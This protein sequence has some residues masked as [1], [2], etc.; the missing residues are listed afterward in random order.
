MDSVPPQDCIQ[1]ANNGVTEIFLPQ[2]TT[3]Q[4]TPLTVYCDQTSAGGGWLMF[5][6]RMNNAEDFPNR[7]WQEYKEGFG[8]LTGSF[9]LGLEYLHEIT[10][11]PATLRITLEDWDG[12]K[13]YAQY[14]DFS[15][16]GED[17]GYR[18]S[19]GS[20]SGDAGDSL[21]YHNGKKFSTIDKDQ[22]SD[23]WHLSQEYGGAWW[24]KD[25]LMYSQLT[26]HYYSSGLN[27]GEHG[28]GV[29]WLRW[30][31]GYYSFKRADDDAEALITA[32]RARIEMDSS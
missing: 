22:D 21:N 10:K 19:V 3:N 9:W 20:Y 6:R 26:G 24:Y 32:S 13:K 11:R 2:P 27:S 28:F 17:D 14:A 12:T 1:S 25:D 15:I 7:V 5:L 29:W 23:S 16:S 8:D 31:G 30:H 4:F 18:L